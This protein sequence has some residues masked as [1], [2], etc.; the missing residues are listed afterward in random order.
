ME[1]T[2]ELQQGLEFR[3]LYRPREGVW[4]KVQWVYIYIGVCM[5][6]RGV[7]YIIYRGCV[8]RC[9]WG[10]LIN[11]YIWVCVW[12]KPVHLWVQV[13]VIFSI[14]GKSRYTVYHLTCKPLLYTILVYLLELLFYNGHIRM[15]HFKNANFFYMHQ[16]S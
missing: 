11:K 10:T 2:V 6:Y 9:G 1:S 14:K 13:G 3:P 8:Y 12:V 15:V 4:V 16:T 5:G 7:L